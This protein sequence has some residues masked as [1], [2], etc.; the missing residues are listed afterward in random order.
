M[1]NFVLAILP[2]R[3]KPINVGQ[4]ARALAGR[5]RSPMVRWNLQLIRCA[6]CCQCAA[7]IVKVIKVYR[8]FA[9]RAFKSNANRRSS[10]FIKNTAST[11]LQHSG[12][13]PRYFTN[14]TPADLDID[15]EKTAEIAASNEGRDVRTSTIVM[16]AFAVLF[17][18]LAVFVAQSWLNSAGRAAH[19]QPRSQQEAGQHAARSWSH[20]SRCASATS[21]RRRS[22]AKSPWPEARCR[23]APSPR[24]PTCS[25]GGKRVVL[26]AI[27]P[28]E[29]VL[30]SKITGP[31]QRATL[32]A[33]LR[34]G[35]KAVD[36]PRQRRR[37]RRRLRAAGRSR[38]R[39][40]DAPGRQGQRQHRGR[41]A[42]RRACWRSTRSPTSAPTS[43]P[44]SRRSRSR[45]T[46]SA[47]RSSRWPLRS[48]PC[49]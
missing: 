11:N 38:R 46:W 30:S 29:P 15:R 23:P 35:L 33:M 19:A 28:N 8:S 32:S 47:R 41:A 48:A 12:I 36:H 22:C 14:S 13:C 26:T 39:R 27:E 20:R 34:D 40:A 49:R 10:R 21:S 6:A 43:R 3:L 4:D 1:L 31:G 37:R 45:S 2:H 24:S 5:G 44:W 16:I 17:G 9:R 25:S 7:A 42:E 18:L